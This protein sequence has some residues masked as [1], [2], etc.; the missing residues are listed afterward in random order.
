MKP[1]YNKRVWLNPETS[2]STGSVVL[3]D[4][5]VKSVDGKR[6]DDI[7]IEIADC[8]NKIRLHKNPEESD[9]DF[10]NKMYCLEGEL[11]NFIER[12]KRKIQY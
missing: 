3:F 2:D 11:T 1:R 9:T 7:F 12:L 4:G 8:R 5:Q 10:I 6:Y